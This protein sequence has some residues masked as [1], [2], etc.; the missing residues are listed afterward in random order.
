[1]TYP[2]LPL[3]GLVRPEVLEKGA[4]HGRALV[5]AVAASGGA[6]GTKALRTRLR[7]N[8]TVHSS[9]GNESRSRDLRRIGQIPIWRLWVQRLYLPVW[10]CEVGWLCDD[11]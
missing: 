8:A 10:L 11:V 3:A 4:A 1:M 2:E 5:V 7:M 6:P 9:T